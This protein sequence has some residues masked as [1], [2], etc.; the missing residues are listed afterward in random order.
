M[1]NPLLT[2]LKPV[3]SGAKSAVT[4]VAKHTI[5]NLAVAVPV[6]ALAGAYLVSKLLSP[7]GVKENVSD[8][9]INGVDRD[10]LIRAELDLAELKRAKSLKSKAKPHDQFL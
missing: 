5:H 6:T 9:I 4:N 2:A 1:A 10:E 7:G 3:V 8:V